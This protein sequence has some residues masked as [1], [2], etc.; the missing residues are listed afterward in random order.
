[1][2]YKLIV[3]DMDGVVFEHCNFWMELHK[4]LGT[5][6]E[7]KALTEKHVKTD[8]STLVD[9]VV[10]RLWK[11]KSAD[12]YHSLVEEV[13]YFRGAAE[14]VAALKQ[15]G[16]LIAIISSGPKDLA[17]RAQKELGIDYVYANELVVEGGMITGEFRWPVAH[18]RKAVVL[19]E[20]AEEHH[21]HLSEIIVVGDSDA[22]IKMMRVAGCGIAFCSDSDA[23]R[24]VATVVVDEKDVRAI[25]P[26]IESFEKKEI[27]KT[28][29]D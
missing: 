24:Q 6:D 29:N 28:M 18:D 4:K 20:L 7:G 17:L 26:H 8:Y 1:M 16:Y 14:A 12:V 5:Y 19:K 25:L 13:G 3:F 10:G 27:F 2:K 21:L 15:K 9:E 11:G 22:D 23:L